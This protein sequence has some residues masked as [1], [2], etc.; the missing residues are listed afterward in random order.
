[1]LPQRSSCWLYLAFLIFSVASSDHAA[2]AFMRNPTNPGSKTLQ[3][4][5][6]TDAHRIFKIRPGGTKQADDRNIRRTHFQS[7]IQQFTESLAA[8][9]NG[10][11]ENSSQD[12]SP[13]S[14]RTKGLLVLLSVPFCWG[15]YVPVVRYLYAIEPPV[16]GFVF[17]LSYY[18]VASITTLFLVVLQGQRARKTDISTDIVT[19]INNAEENTGDENSK[20]IP[21]KAGLE[22]GGYLFVAN[23]L[24]VIGLK[25]VPSDRAGFLVQLTTV[26]V[27]VAEALFAGDLLAIP[28]RTWF[29]CLLAFAGICVMNLDGLGGSSISTM[30][31]AFKTFTQGDLLILSAAVLY[32]LH[33]V[34]L[35]RYAKESTPLK[36]AASK[37]S[38]ETI[39]SFGL[40]MSLIVY[41]G[42][43]AGTNAGGLLSFA[44]QTGAEIS[45][46]FSTI[47]QG[48]TAGTVPKAA[49]VS[50]LGATVWTGLV[51]TAY[52]IYAQSYGQRRVGPTTA[53]LVYSI[54][55]L[56]TSF[57][58]FLL[59]GETMG[60]AGVVGGALIGSALYLVTTG[61][62]NNETES[63]NKS[64][65]K[66]MPLRI[67]GDEESSNVVDGEEVVVDVEGY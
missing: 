9:K 38:V 37:A 8:L 41:A 12:R 17:S 44:Q 11:A 28:T 55:P 1:M 26:M 42:S 63:K 30:L 14:E 62:N 15:T 25:T 33:V 50:A 45:N 16:P 3:D 6:H 2:D 59:L 66:A 57:F 29:S 47:S 51:T 52:T 60:P 13:L 18:A 32:A 27:P 31:L 40:V 24:Q 36:L 22:L 4:V 5:S 46:F 35:G 56:T 39:Y 20:P 10:D 21:I 7:R 43:G 48:L 61:S 65:E 23:C 19:N 53:N 34:R 49:I 64:G 54:Q 58:A 67:N